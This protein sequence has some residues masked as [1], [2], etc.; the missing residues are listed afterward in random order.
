[1]AAAGVVA[2]GAADV[3]EVKNMIAQ[4]PSLGVGIGYREALR[5]EIF[6]YRDEIDFLEIIA[7][8]YIDA[9][10]A[11]MRELA[12]LAEHFT[13][14][15]HG[16]NLSLG[17][18]QGIDLNYLDKLARLIDQI[19][20]PW[21]SEHISFTQAGGIDIG[22]LS[23]LPYSQAAIDILCENIQQAR[24]CIASPL[25]LE[26]ITYML[27]LPGGE[28]SEAE[29]IAEVAE[30][31]DCG[32]LLDI[33]NLH[34]NAVNHGYDIDRFLDRLPLKRI[35]Q[36]HF[37]G[38][39]WHDG[40]LIDSHSQPTAS[41]VWHLMNKIINRAPVKGIILERDENFPQFAELLNELR[42]ARQIARQFQWV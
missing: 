1:M 24:Q 7:D 37:A 10:P 39:Y 3:A 18:A 14:I 27:N 32:L 40:L 34:I 28:M 36:L 9:T 22:H 11:K 17:S 30:Q 12:M 20:P 13:L 25:I 4:L 21:W 33:A 19:N 16:I 35:V 2:A 23:P 31:A 38:G 8:H 41:Q 26:N 42:R 6:L 5:G 15:P 29:F